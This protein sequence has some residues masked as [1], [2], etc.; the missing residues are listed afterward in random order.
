MQ[1]RARARNFASI[2]C[3][4]LDSSRLASLSLSRC[5]IVG[6][7][8][9]YTAP[10]GESKRKRESRQFPAIATAGQYAIARLSARPLSQFTT[11]GLRYRCSNPSSRYLWSTR[12]SSQCIL[13]TGK[14]KI[15]IILCVIF[16]LLYNSFFIYFFFVVSSL[17]RD[18]DRSKYEITA[19]I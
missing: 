17:S 11:R 4:S 1:L 7:T 14:V 15:F 12:F 18:F 10:R 2:H 13:F 16:S 3:P 6:G 8:V 19:K 5:A 9:A